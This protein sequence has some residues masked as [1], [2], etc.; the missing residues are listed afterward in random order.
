MMRSGRR[1]ALGTSLFAAT[2]G[3]GSLALGAVERQGTWPEDEA[4]VSVDVS[5]V[6]RTEALRELAEVAGWSL[7]TKDV[8][9]GTVDL[10]IQGQSPAKVLELLLEDG[11][12]VATRDGTLVSIT[13]RGGSVAS[14]PGGGA[15]APLAPPV[16][17]APLAPPAPPAP[18]VA[19]PPPL[20]EDK[21][22]DRLVTGGDL[23]IEVGEVVHDVAVIGGE[24]TVRGIVTGDLSIV[25]GQATVA[26]GG[27]VGGDL[28]VLGGEAVLEE[29][30]RVDG[31][32]EIV[33]GALDRNDGAIVGGKVVQ[34]GD[35]EAEGAEESEAH[36]EG[37]LVTL[38][39]ATS[40]SAMLFVLGAVLLSVATERVRRVAAE[41]AARPARCFGLGL[42]WTL[43]S[44]VILVALCVTIIGIPIAL[45]GMLLFALGL[46][47]GGAAAL[48]TLGHAAL[49]HRTDNPYAHLAAGAAFLLVAR[50]V[51]GVG[52]FLA[53]GAIV[54]GFGAFVATRA[55]G[56]WPERKKV[57]AQNMG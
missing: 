23:V 27:R 13:R 28:S 46:L 47:G 19:P 9:G 7:I 20:P 52:D 56:Y 48:L 54:I 24:V 31:S 55:A 26:P 34:Q 45:L 16:P 14:A 10:R 18:P 21:G 30:A 42:L 1:L 6:S 39:E 35:D 4:A 17:P 41:V 38:G 36:E 32:I 33:G 44:A 57:T 12:Y 22:S 2:M 37:F 53:N 15:P 3:W 5:A 50:L 25:G 11:D 29:G 40:Q 43:L 49:R 51:P 8:G